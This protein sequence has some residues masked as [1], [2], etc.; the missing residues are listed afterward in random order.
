MVTS[1]VL[2]LPVADGGARRPAPAWLLSDPR[3]LQWTVADGPG[4]RS[5]EE[6]EPRT[7]V[8]DFDHVLPDGTS[9]ADPGNA[10]WLAFA[11]R[12]AVLL[13]EHETSRIETA[14]MHAAQV[15]EM[16]KLMSFMRLGDQ[17]IMHFEDLRRADVERFARAVRYG[18]A[19]VLDV[20][21]R[22][23]RL[24]AEGADL[25]DT[26]EVRRRLHL[27]INLDISDA[28]DVAAGRSNGADRKPLTHN[29]QF[30]A[31]LV[32]EHLWNFRREI[33]GGNIRFKPFET[34]ASAEAAKHRTD[35]SRTPTIPQRQ[36]MTLIDGCIR[37]V[38]ELGPTVASVRDAVEAAIAGV[39]DRS[40]RA[41]AADAAIAARGADVEAI[42][43]RVRLPAD[44]GAYRV[45]EHATVILVQA[46]FVLIAALSARRDAE[47][48][49]LGENCILGGDGSR[50]V[51]SA[52]LKTE[53]ENQHTPVPDVV[54]RI[55]DRLRT[56][57]SGARTASGSTR[58]FCWFDAATYRAIPRVR[59]IVPSDL[60]R[61]ATLCDVPPHD[62]AP[63]RFTVR[64]FRRFFA[65]LYMWRHENPDLGA[66]RLHLRH[67]DFRQTRAYCTDRTLGRIFTEEQRGFTRTVVTEAMAGVR[68]VGGAAGGR[69]MAMAARLKPRFAGV[70]AME[71]ER[72]ADWSARIADRMVVRCNPWSYC[73]CPDTRRGAKD[74]NCRT[75][76]VPSAVGPDLARATPETCVGCRHRMTDSVFAPFM[77]TEIALGE[78]MLAS[79]RVA[80]T[81]VAL[82][83][84]KRL[85]VLRAHVEAADAAGVPA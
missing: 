23:A 76:D 84:A 75:G 69:L 55:V 70:V 42:R 43:A 49:T 27:P 59:T 53:R 63:W 77:R 54:A 21:R 35:T 61:L 28:L 79:K 46:C 5:G 45:V 22:A 33:E 82:A 57:G 73:T 36:A 7:A 32:L 51:Y 64:Q 30:R 25:S 9:L 67:W 13:R 56:L 48:H 31:L 81:A 50:Y 16:F 39:E 14:G 44:A 26:P 52:I 15:R 2:R 83:T 11:M 47:V 66:L 12:Y 72:L 60:D 58:L 4:N 62:G 38:T 18:T 80:G 20:V 17:P 1:N 24:A 19:E 65:I 41:A 3:S 34:S 37:L 8:I 10:D 78:R 40:A 68:Q 29:P 85:E 6:G 71:P 74:A